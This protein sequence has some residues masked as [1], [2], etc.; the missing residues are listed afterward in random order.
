[1]LG[2]TVPSIWGETPVVLNI[3]LAVLL[4]LLSAIALRPAAAKKV[5]IQVENAPLEDVLKLLEQ[6][7]GYDIETMTRPEE[8]L[9]LP[10]GITLKAEN[11]H[12]KKVLRQVCEQAGCH[13]QHWRD[14]F[15]VRNGPSRESPLRAQAGPLTISVNQVS[16]TGSSHRVNY[17]S[18][19]PRVSHSRPTGRIG[20]RFEGYEDAMRRIAYLHLELADSTGRQLELGHRYS[21]HNLNQEIITGHSFSHGLVQE[22]FP[23][24]VTRAR[25]DSL[26]LSGLVGTY[27]KVETVDFRFD[28]LQTDGQTVARAGKKVTLRT[29]SLS[30]RR[31]AFNMDLEGFADPEPDGPRQGQPRQNACR[32]LTQ[33]YIVQHDGTERPVYGSFWRG[34]GASISRI[35]RESPK[36]IV[37]RLWRR[38]DLGPGEE[39]RIEDIALPRPE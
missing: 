10:V 28:D 11:E 2:V 1:M 29:V 20:L 33:L 6:A 36:A 23:F 12:F 3:R 5:S 22:D 16:I 13:Y 24:A 19:E 21:M 14:G 7:S 32:D 34:G 25:G 4:A 26:I 9:G 18:G 17:R 35:E 15:R 31:L 38:S 27:G 37:L 30:R 8:K 39:F